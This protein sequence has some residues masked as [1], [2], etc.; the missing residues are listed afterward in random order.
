MFIE[1][2]DKNSS[3]AELW[4]ACAWP[5]VNVP[6]VGEKVFYFPQ[7]HLE[8]DYSEMALAYRPS[9]A[10]AT[11]DFKYG[12]R[13]VQGGGRSSARETIGRVAAGAVAKIILRAYAGTEAMVAGHSVYTSS[14]CGKVDKEDSWFLES[15]Q[16]H[17]GQATTFLRHIKEGVDIASK[18]E[19]ALLLFSGGE[20]RK[21]AGPRS[22]AQS[23]WA[24][25]ES[26]D[27]LIGMFELMWPY[28]DKAICKTA[29]NI[30]KPIIAEQIPK[31]KIDS[32]EFEELTLGCLPPTFQEWVMMIA[33]LQHLIAYTLEKIMTI[34]KDIVSEKVERVGDGTTRVVLFAEEFLKEAKLFI[35]DGVHSKSYT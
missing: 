10:D 32:V 18:D 6:R 35:E 16:K 13:A 30:A 21:D 17:P 9:L 26:K 19:E 23:Y 5:F 29:K 1:N 27:W 7:G 33:L 20:T 12:V 24:V 2:G 22:E 11:Y 8:Q 14:S 15:Y 25:A 3:Y 34:N 31:Y 4:H 28:L